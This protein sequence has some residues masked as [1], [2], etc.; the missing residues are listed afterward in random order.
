MEQ[1]QRPDETGKRERKPISV[2]EANSR[3]SQI[4]LQSDC[5][6]K[7]E[8]RAGENR[9]QRH[10]KASSASALLNGM[11]V[12]IRDYAETL[13]LSVVEV[14]SVLAVVLTMPTIQ[15]KN[16]ESEDQ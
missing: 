10:F 16:R 6:I 8:K 14:L 1:K 9:Y 11:A 3:A 2:E 5:I 4:G 7:L 13:N 12:L 15:E